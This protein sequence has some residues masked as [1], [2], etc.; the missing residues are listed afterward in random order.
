[1][2]K[3]GIFLDLDN[4][5]RNGG[6]GIRYDAIKLLVKAQGAV[7]LRANAYM[8]VD[9]EREAR[10]PLLGQ[11]RRDYRDAIRRYGYNLALKPMRRY[12]T[13]EG[14]IVIKANCDVDLAVDALL[15]SENLDY[16]LLGS[17]DGDF[18]GMVRALQSRGKRVDLLTFGNASSE[19]RRQVD[20]HFSG[21]LMPGILPVDESAPSRMRGVMISVNEEKGYGFLAVRTGLGPTD[22]RSDVFCHIMD[23]SRDGRSV[24]NEQFAN[25]KTRGAIIEFDL[26]DSG[27]GRVKAAN[28]R[29]YRWG[30]RP[31]PA[32][33]VF[34]DAD[35]DAPPA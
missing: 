19:L 18:L 25:L 27:D 14:E 32:T 6:W 5:S 7:V 22:I 11:K 12:V 33:P 3:A 8:A 15:Q 34:D 23:F 29:E 28:A 1:M 16:I 30:E 17:G 20:N 13:D 26:T 2:I 10:D 4:L 35:E 21:F 9:E 31:A 24:S